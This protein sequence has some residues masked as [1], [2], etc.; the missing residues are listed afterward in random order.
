MQQSSGI[1][2]SS[3]LIGV[4]FLVIGVFII[5]FPEENLFAITWLIGLLF[6]ING[7]IEIFIRRVMKK[8]SQ[9]GTNILVILGVINII[10]GLLILFNVVTSTTF[11]IYLFAIWF[12]INAIFNI[13]TVTPSEKSNKVF[14][15]F[16]ILLNIVEIVFGLILLFNPLMA[17]LLI[18]IFMCIVFFIIGITYIIDALN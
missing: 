8:A 18:A 9:S 11:I 16:S 6:I 17:A 7:F 2:W 5:S 10:I 13:F 3:L 15:T 12:I 14:H 1:K 4:I